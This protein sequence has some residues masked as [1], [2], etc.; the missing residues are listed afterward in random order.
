MYKDEV[1]GLETCASHN[2][3]LKKIQEAVQKLLDKDKEENDG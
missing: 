2:E 3:I 1:P